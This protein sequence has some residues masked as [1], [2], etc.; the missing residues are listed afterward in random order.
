[1]CTLGEFVDFVKS[2]LNDA[3]PDDNCA[4]WSRA[5]VAQYIINAISTTSSRRPDLFT[6]TVEIELSPGCI[7]Y[8]C[9]TCSTFGGVLSVDGNSCA[10]D[11]EPSEYGR[12]LQA[13]L[14]GSTYGQ[15]SPIVSFDEEG[16]Y[17]HGGISYDP[18]NPCVFR[19]KNP[20]PD[21]GVIATIYCAKTPDT[22][23]ITSEDSELPS[24][25]CGQARNAVLEYALY[26]AYEVDQELDTASEKQQMHF[27]NFV[28]L[29]Q[30]NDQATDKYNQDSS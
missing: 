5:L 28:T 13:R 18:K 6:E 30:L 15:C 4:T 29:L 8:I 7:H 24:A 2:Q 12:K 21:R 10:V 20:V 1:M 22:S 17:E 26:Q 19:T 11:E 23:S 25:A 9:D 16:S 27:N 3:D 14:A